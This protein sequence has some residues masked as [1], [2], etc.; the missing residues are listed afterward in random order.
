MKFPIQGICT[1][2]PL[3]GECKN[4]IPRWF[5]SKRHKTCYL[6]AYGACLGGANNFRTRW[7]CEKTCRE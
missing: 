3:K 4:T 7:E 1:L 5:Y 2:D 6:Y